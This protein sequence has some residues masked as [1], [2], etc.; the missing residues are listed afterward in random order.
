MFSLFS[1]SAPAAAGVRRVAPAEAAQLVREQKAVLVDVRETEEWAAT[2]VAKPAAMLS[3]I[4]LTGPRDQWTPFLRQV[5]DREIILY[6]RSGARSGVAARLLAAEGFKT[7]DLGTLRS[8]H[9][10]GLPV[11]KPP[12]VR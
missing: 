6:C 4:D 3:F 1:R 8:W 2:G 12:G 11:C 5:G 10:A 9:R 7:A